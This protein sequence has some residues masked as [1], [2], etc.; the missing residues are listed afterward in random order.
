MLKT[1]VYSK[2]FVVQLIDSSAIYPIV[3]IDIL[4]YEL[5]KQT[6]K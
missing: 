5:F 2:P 1:F 4:V 3:D 6:V